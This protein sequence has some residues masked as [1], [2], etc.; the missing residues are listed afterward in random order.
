MRRSIFCGLILAGTMT[1]A[2]AA[3]PTGDWRVKDGVAN[4]R[5]AICNDHLWGAVSWEKTPGGLDKENP[6]RAKQTRTTLGAAIL[7][8]MVKKNPAQDVWDGKIYDASGGHIWTSKVVYDAQPDELEVKGC[9]LGMCMGETWKR[10]P[11]T[12]PGS[13]AEGAKGPSATVASTNP[14]LMAPAGAKKAPAKAAPAKTTVAAPASTAVGPGDIGDVCAL[15]EVAA[16][17]AQ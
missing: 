6:D 5:V 10:P 17:P 1:S 9:F 13:I 8:G 4:I 3:D 14:N 11:A 16:G 2:M 15:P 7:L 12:G